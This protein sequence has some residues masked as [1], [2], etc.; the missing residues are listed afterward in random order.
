MANVGRHATNLLGKALRET[1]QQLDRI[2]LTITG[3]EAFKSTLSRHRQIMPLGVDYAP[4]VSTV[5]T[6]IA[7]NASVVGRVTVAEGGSVWYSSVLRADTESSSIT[8]GK[9]SNIQDRSVLVAEGGDILIG[10]NVTVGH[11]AIMEGNITIGDFCLI[12]QGS[13]LGKNTTVH[14]KSIIAAGAVVL[15]NTTV[16]SG[17]MWAGNP[18]K[19]IRDVK[20]TEAATMEP[21]A[22]HYTAL[23]E[24]H[25]KSF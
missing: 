15:P 19:F 13:I 16:P 3:V 5:R 9:N 11:G 20:A 10:D 25:S 2:G 18:A 4:N 1:G 7:P 17:Q 14:A 22:T 6:F 24:E 23:A 8:I 12:G 21:Q